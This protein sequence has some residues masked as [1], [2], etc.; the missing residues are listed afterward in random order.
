MPKKIR[1]GVLGGGGDS[2]SQAQRAMSRLEK[3]IAEAKEEEARKARELELQREEEVKLLNRQAEEER[4]ASQKRLETELTEQK[5]E[6]ERL[7]SQKRLEAEIAEQK[8]PY[9]NKV[10]AQELLKEME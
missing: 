9:F 7:A 2:L 10:R 4:L 5:A 6:E 8:G 3:S 1:L